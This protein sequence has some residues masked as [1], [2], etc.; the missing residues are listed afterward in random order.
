[1]NRTLE[2]YNQ[3]Y[4]HMTPEY[5]HSKGFKNYIDENNKSHI[6]FLNSVTE[7]FPQYDIANKSVLELGCGAQGLI[8]YFNQKYCSEYT[9]VD[10]SNIAISLARELKSQSNFI[11]EYLCEDI[12]DS[13]VDLSR[14]FDL[15]YDS[16]LLHCL[17][18]KE[19]KEYFQFLKSHMHADSVF[20]CE[21]MVFQKLFKLPIGY[22]FDENYQVL[23]EVGESDIP[24][25]TVLPFR[26]LESE[27]LANGFKIS[28]LYYHSELSINPFPDFL[29]HPVA[30]RP[31]LVRLIVTLG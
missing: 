16:H 18:G 5:I 2:L 10:F 11:G 3:S 21:S 8:E 23:K 24:I 13:S 31:H 14:K 12:S 6:K 29:D 15:L 30:H 4:A 25:R 22:S 19:R 28:Y 9:G 20:I 26:D 1:M 27:L 7:Q 17:C